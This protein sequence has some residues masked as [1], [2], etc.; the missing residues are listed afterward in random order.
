MASWVLGA[1]I[2]IPFALIHRFPSLPDAGS[3]RTVAVAG[4]VWRDGLGYLL[5]TQEP[6]IPYLLYGPL[7]AMG[8][9]R[10]M[11]VIAGIFLILL[12]GLVAFIAWRITQRLWASIVASLAL[13]SF[14]VTYELASR[15]LLRPAA[16]LFGYLA[17]LLAVMGAD[18]AGK[19]RFWLLGAGAFAV[20]LA[21]ESHGIGQLFL[22]VPGL[23][24]V[25]RPSRPGLR[26]AVLMSGLML[27]LLIPRLTIN[28][29][30]GGF[31]NFRTNRADW[32]VAEGYLDVVNEQFFRHPVHNESSSVDYALFIDDMARDAVGWSGLVAIFLAAFSPI[33]ARRKV[34]LFALAGCA[35]VVVGLLMTKP[36]PLPRYLS[37]LLP[38]LAI[39]AACGAVRVKELRPS[40]RHSWVPPALT[41]SLVSVIA[42]ISLTQWQERASASHDTATGSPYAAIVER[43]GHGEGVIGSNSYEMNRLDPRIPTYGHHVLS[44]SEWLTFLTWPSDEAVRAMLEKRGVEWAVVGLRRGEVSYHQTWVSAA[45]GLE[46]RHDRRLATSPHFC[47]VLD[48]PPAVLYRAAPCGSP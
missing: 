8:S 5:E 40:M 11:R 16:L 7:T 20:V 47:R 36:N 1:L 44:E 48:V 42:G 2:C 4:H 35:I 29:A 18:A 13:M 38:G 41:L 15:L 32:F 26:T 31:A 25:V 37:P 19:R 27:I 3:A 39:A 43:M 9:V 45:Y 30:E 34:I 12:S 10:G 22:A 17:I 21:M 24:W 14:A 28:F 46:V 23:I 6:L 33:K